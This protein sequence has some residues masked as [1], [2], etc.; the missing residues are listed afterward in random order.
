MKFCGIDLHSNNSVIVVSDA[1]DRTVLQRRLP[2]DLEA[3]LAAPAPYRGELQGV[4][5]NRPIMHSSQSWKQLDYPLRKICVS[6]GFTAFM[7]GK[8]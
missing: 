6:G 8:R 5:W 3:I 7:L 1:E 2:N 4:S